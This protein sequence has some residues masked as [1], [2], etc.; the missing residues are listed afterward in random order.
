KETSGVRIIASSRRDLSH[1][2][3]EG[4]FREDLYYR[5]NVVRI[6][7]PALRQR[8]DDI[9]ELVRA[10]VLRG[11]R[12]GLPE[13]TYE[14]AALDLLK[15]HDWP[16]NVREL[17]NLVLRLSALTADP[18]VSQRDLEREI[19]KD[20]LSAAPED[21]SFEAE[22]HALLHKHVM[23]DMLSGDSENGVYAQ[24]IES[25]ERPLITLA[26]SVT[27]GNKVRAAALLGLNR[28]TLRAKIQSL[29]IAEE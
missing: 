5:L 19:R 10:F 18:I 2:I 15:V 26:L 24:V 22:V 3:E 8:K 21:N 25:V 28:N 20:F 13:K 27:G 11:V 23:G 7:M 9:T 4:A 16:G 12:Q 1:L 6:D 29:G 14:P 17:E